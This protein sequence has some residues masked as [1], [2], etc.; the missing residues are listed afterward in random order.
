M[1]YKIEIKY[2]IY[3]NENGLLFEPKDSYGSNLYSNYYDSVEEAIEY[4]DDADY[5][6]IP[7]TVKVWDWN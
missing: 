5:L 3:V 6:I 1:S 2:R 4:I 7:V